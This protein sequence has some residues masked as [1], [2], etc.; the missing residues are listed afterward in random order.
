VDTGAL[1]AASAAT[2]AVAQMAQNLVKNNASGVQQRHWV[3][4]VQVEGF[5]EA[6]GDDDNRKKRRPVPL[7]YNPSSSILVLGFGSVGDAQRAYLTKEEKSKVS[8]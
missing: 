4:S 3:I 5:G 6:P 1:T 2:S 7:G 8:D